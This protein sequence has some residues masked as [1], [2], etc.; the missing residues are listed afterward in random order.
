[1]AEKLHIV[2]FGAHIGD[3]EITCGHVLAKYARAG[4]KA[5][6][7]HVTPG[8]KGHPT[9]SP[10]EYEKQKREETAAS[11]KVW[12]CDV[13]IMPFKDG[14]T[15]LTEESKLMFADV[16]RELKPDIVITHWKGSFHK[17]HINTHYNVLEGVFYAAVPGIKRAL[18]AHGIKQL[19]FADNWEDALEFTPHVYVDI[20]DTYDLW[21][22][23]IAKH[24][25]FRG[26]V[27]SFQYNE[28]YTGLSQA[29]GAIAGYKRAAAF[30]LPPFSTFRKFDM[31]PVHE[32]MLIY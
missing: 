15:Y 21:K 23:G 8:E 31:F 5:T 27:S 29:R 32:T 25:L 17:D 14:E 30:M 1:M 7:V 22:E 28:Y 13:R 9:L 6:I 3:A 24:G 18:P 26:E 12:G 10:Q 16:I 2:Y 20:T 11:A 4:H 19:Y